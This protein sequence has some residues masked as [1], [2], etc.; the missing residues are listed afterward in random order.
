M[1]TS[2]SSDIEA[3]DGVRVEPWE[4]DTLGDTYVEKDEDGSSFFYRVQDISFRD[5]W[6][7][8]DVSKNLKKMR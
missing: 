6:L 7:Q 1:T 3:R 5:A 2:T 8:S 4:D